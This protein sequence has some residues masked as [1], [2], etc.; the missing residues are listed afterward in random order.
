LWSGYLYLQDT[1]SPSRYLH[2]T[3]GAALEYSQQIDTN[4]INMMKHITWTPH[5]AVNWDPTRDGKTVVRAA[6]NQYVDFGALLVS[7]FSGP[8]VFTRTCNFNNGQYNANCRDSGGSWNTIGRPGG[9]DAIRNP[10]GP[11][12]DLDAPR[13]TEYLFGIDRELPWQLGA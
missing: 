6:F 5:V 7:D 3:P 11:R 4:N 9:R 12:K 10:I 8:Q 13:T 1:W 2:I